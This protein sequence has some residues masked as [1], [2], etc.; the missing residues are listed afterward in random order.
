MMQKIDESVK[1]LK[2]YAT[3]TKNPV[4]V[5]SVQKQRSQKY[6]ISKLHKL[7]PY[8]RLLVI[9]DQEINDL[10]NPYMLIWRVVNNIDVQRDIVLEPFMAIDGTNKNS[11]DGYDREWPKD[12]LC[13]R[14]VLESLRERGLVEWDEPFASK[15]GLL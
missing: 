14:E 8:I 5:I 11:H 10:N 15:W 2:Q 7:S 6:L 12:T 13:T 1:E 3:D 4:C 9:V